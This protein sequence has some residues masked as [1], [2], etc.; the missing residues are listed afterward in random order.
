MSSE[1]TR[2]LECELSEACLEEDL[3][4]VEQLLASG[5][6]PGNPSDCNTA[7]HGALR[8]RNSGLVR[9]LLE[10]GA[11][12]NRATSTSSVPLLVAIESGRPELSQLLL[13]H[14]ARPEGVSWWD[15]IPPGDDAEAVRSA[16]AARMD[17]NRSD[18]KH[19]TAA[20]HLAAMYGYVDCLAE[21][22]RGG[23]DPTRR[24]AEGRTPLDRAVQNHH[25]D[26]VERL[27]S[28]PG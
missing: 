25:L 19:G 12:P 17:P 8:G 21:L 9:L 26:V 14:G 2:C 15:I 20:L 27:R 13:A 5:A 24:D 4:R 10:H 23:A 16:L 7:L 6:D 28:W 3:E 18:P 22:L 11:D 1:E